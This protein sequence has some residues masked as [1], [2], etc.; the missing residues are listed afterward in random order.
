MIQRYGF[1]NATTKKNI[2]NI[3]LAITNNV[4]QIVFNWRIAVVFHF[5]ILTSENYCLST[6]AIYVFTTT[7][8]YVL[9]HFIDCT[10]TSSIST[11]VDLRNTK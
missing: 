6:T 1:V 7:H 5:M 10:M 11:L 8:F 2:F 4:P 3:N 9:Y